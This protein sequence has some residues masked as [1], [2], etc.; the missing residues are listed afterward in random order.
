MLAN[1]SD[2]VPALNQ[3][4]ASVSIH[5]GPARAVRVVLEQTESGSMIGVIMYA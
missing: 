1:V 5:V 4:W 2:A 3:R